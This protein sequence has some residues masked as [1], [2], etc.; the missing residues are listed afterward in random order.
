MLALG[1]CRPVCTNESVENEFFVTTGYF[2]MHGF[3]ASTVWIDKM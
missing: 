2:A 1:P 3:A